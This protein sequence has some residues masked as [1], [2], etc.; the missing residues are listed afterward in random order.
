MGQR[1]RGD[2]VV[3]QQHRHVWRRQ[4]RQVGQGYGLQGRRQGPGQVGPG[5]NQN[6]HSNR[7]A[8]A[9][10]LGRR[11]LAEPEVRP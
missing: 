8:K 9:G 6:G 1:I 2:A 10:E 3:V 7:V 11:D 5:V 4:G